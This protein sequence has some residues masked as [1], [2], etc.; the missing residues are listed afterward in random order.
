MN[1]FTLLPHAYLLHWRYP[2]QIVTGICI[3]I[4]GFL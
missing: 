1:E 4:R 2:F 3:S